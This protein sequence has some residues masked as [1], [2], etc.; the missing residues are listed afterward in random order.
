MA[1]IVT[2]MNSRESE[3]YRL[4]RSYHRRAGAA[5]AW[6]LLARLESEALSQEHFLEI[7]REELA[8]LP[9]LN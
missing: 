6:A 1:Q 3:L 4:L 5:G 9:V 2:P 7:V 8:R